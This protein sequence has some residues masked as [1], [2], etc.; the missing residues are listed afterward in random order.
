MAKRFWMI[1]ALRYDGIDER[2]GAPR[3]MLITVR[4]TG[5]PDIP[6][7]LG[8]FLETFRSV[9]HQSQFIA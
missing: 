8:N 9:Y 5:I 7:A 4:Y 2:I 3:F 1:G 6:P